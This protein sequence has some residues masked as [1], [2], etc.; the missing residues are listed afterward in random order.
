MRHDFSY[1]ATLSRTKPHAELLNEFRSQQQQLMQQIEE[2]SSDL[3][4][5]TA[6]DSGNSSRVKYILSGMS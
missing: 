3:M 2:E 5:S 6:S 4:N 1:P